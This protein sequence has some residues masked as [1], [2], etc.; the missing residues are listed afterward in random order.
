MV[1]TFLN[2]FDS[3][4][5]QDV[6]V[7]VIV[8]ATVLSVWTFTLQPAGGGAVVPVRI[9]LSTAVL[10]LACGLLAVFRLVP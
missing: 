2:V 4:W 8:L 6:L 5:L 10:V 3:E 9:W 7:G 1:A